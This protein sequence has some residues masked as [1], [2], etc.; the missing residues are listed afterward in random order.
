MINLWLLSLQKESSIVFQMFRACLKFCIHGLALFI[1]SMAMSVWVKQLF[2]FWCYWVYQR[3]I[4]VF[5]FNFLTRML[6]IVFSVA[7]NFFKDCYI[8]CQNSKRLKIK[9]NGYSA[10]SIEYMPLVGPVTLRW[11]GSFVLVLALVF[12]RLREFLSSSC[13]KAVILIA[14]PMI[15]IHISKA[16]WIGFTIQKIICDSYFYFLR[17]RG[18][19]KKTAIP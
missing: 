15:C 18:G 19:G 17:K 7:D 12:A 10:G 2:S 6:F 14:K 3:S 9:P 11:P 16:C 5:I 13:C 4:Q 8:P 1:G